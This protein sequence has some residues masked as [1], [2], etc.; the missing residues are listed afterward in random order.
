MHWGMTS[1]YCLVFITIQHDTR[2][3]CSMCSAL[4][5]ILGFIDAGLIKGLE[6][7]N[8]QKQTPIHNSAE[9]GVPHWHWLWST[10]ETTVLV[11]NW[12]TDI[13]INAASSPRQKM[14]S[15]RMHSIVIDQFKDRTFFPILNVKSP[16]HSTACNK[17][18]AYAT[19][20][21]I[22]LHVL[23]ILRMTAN[24]HMMNNYGISSDTHVISQ[25]ASYFLMWF[26][27]VLS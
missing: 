11:N 18:V 5:K 27:L 6:P 20:Q 13:N 1:C 15:L 23:S 25:D 24:E 14:S 22:I 21:T 4:S 12:H 9:A 19:C 16:H 17:Y 7:N 8:A 2:G 3:L 26:G 10:E